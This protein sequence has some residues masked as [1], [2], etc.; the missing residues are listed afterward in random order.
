M[1][2]VEEEDDSSSDD[3]IDEDVDGDSIKHGSIKNS[4]N[5]NSIISVT[6]N[7]NDYDDDND[8]QYNNNNYQANKSIDHIQK[9]TIVKSG[10]ETS[11]INCHFTT[12]VCVYDGY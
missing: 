1:L 12:I 10:D 4:I 11:K 9:P 6:N 8:R 2:V 5:Q 7:R 3:G